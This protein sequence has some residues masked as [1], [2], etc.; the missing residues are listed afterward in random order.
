MVFCW[1]YKWKIIIEKQTKS[2][3]V[4]SVLTVTARLQSAASHG[5]HQ[6]LDGLPYLV[7]PPDSSM[8]GAA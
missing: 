7:A 1:S 2:L 4:V 3:E 8:L 6:L 5:I